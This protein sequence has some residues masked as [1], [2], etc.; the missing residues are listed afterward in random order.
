MVVELPYQQPR[1]SVLQ[2]WGYGVLLAALLC[3]AVQAIRCGV[4]SS[5]KLQGLL[6]QQVA[7]QDLNH[8]AKARSD[9]FQDKISLYSSPLGV[10]EMARERLSM[11]EQDEILVRLYPPAVA[12]H[13]D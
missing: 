1:L 2:K 3:V 5:V 11:V 8:Q 10:E 4:A 13:R 7:V 12:Q 9:M 6:A